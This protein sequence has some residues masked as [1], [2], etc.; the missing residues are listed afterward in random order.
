MNDHARNPSLASGAA[1]SAAVPE[2]DRAMDRYAD[3]DDGAFSSVYALLYPRLRRFLLRLSGDATQADDLTQETL[4]R[5]HRAR[6]SFLRGASALSWAFAIAR[7]AYRDQLRSRARKGQHQPLIDPDDEGAGGGAHASPDAGAD[8]WVM[9]RETAALLR[10]AIAALPV[11]QREAFLLLRFEGMSVAE[12][13]E[14]LG[15]TEAA[16]KLRAFRAYET[17]RSVLAERAAEPRAER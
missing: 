1:E 15:A 12:A 7:N 4:L 9:A 8:Q 17:L 14:V 6:G 2:L 10:D 11:A 3:G 5:V 16:V 13:A